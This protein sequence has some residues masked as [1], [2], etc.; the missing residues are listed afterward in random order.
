MN[1][2]YTIIFSIMSGLA[3]RAGGSDKFPKWVRRIG[4]SLCFVALM[5]LYGAFVSIATSLAIVLSMLMLYGCLTTYWK[6]E[7]IDVMWFHWIMTGFMY[8]FAAIPYAWVTGKWLGFWIRCVVLALF[9]VIWSEYNTDVVKEEVG[10][11]SM[12]IATMPLLIL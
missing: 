1:I 10:R 6:G 11:G 8:G 3:Y 4:C 2:L 12:L 7:A 5:G 9:T